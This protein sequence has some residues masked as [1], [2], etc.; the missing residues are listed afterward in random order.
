MDADADVE[1]EALAAM[2]RGD[3]RG[4]LHILA[5][6]LGVPVF[7]YCRRMLGED[8]AADDAMQATFAQAYERLASFERRSSLRSWVFA[9]AH[10][11]CLDALKASRRFRRRFS[12]SSTLPEPAAPDAHPD[13]AMAA[14]GTGEALGDCLERLE[15]HVR[16]AVLLRYQEGFSYEDMARIARERAGTLQARVSRAMPLL[17]H[18]LEAKGVEP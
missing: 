18:C 7:R 11:R 15:P 14:R 10:Y 12:L 17:R 9:I 3:R 5:R 6:E 2:A 4:A 1:A 16:M 13:E 8:A